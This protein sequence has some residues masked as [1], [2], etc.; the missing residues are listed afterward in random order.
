MERT[1][2]TIEDTCNAGLC[3]G[4]GTC[5]GLCPNS[6]IHMSK[7]RG[8]YVPEIDKKECNRC[9]VCFRVCPGHS[10]DFE[11]LNLM[12]FGKK[13]HKSLIGSYVDCYIGHSTDLKIRYNSSSGG[14]ITG[15]LIFALNEG[16]IDGA[17]VTRMSD[18]RPLDPE[19]FIAKTADEIIGASRSKYCPVPVNIAIKYVLKK[20]GKFAIVGL[21]CH[22]E[23]I[24]KAEIINKELAKKIVL[25]LGLFCNHAPTFLATTYLLEKMNLKKEDV[26]KIDY[27][28]EGWPGRISVTLKNGEKKSVKYFDPYYWGHVFNSYFFTSRCILCNDKV[29]ELSDISFG[30]AWHQSNSKIGESI[31]VSRNKIGEE[32]LRKAAENREIDLKRINNRNVLESQGLY[33]VKRR[34]KARILV[35]KKLGKEVPTYNQKILESKPSDYAAALLSYLRLSISSKPQLWRLLDI[36]PFL[37]THIKGSRND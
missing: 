23:G 21:P 20:N 13:Q 37:M 31:V 26:K 22:I 2:K 8:V 33:L 29:C 12:I 27:R 25:H 3:T 6:A 14:L 24:R 7:I 11:K 30:D 15:L 35:F 17:L 4:C 36:Y 34:H 10:V 9:G 19:V 18:A 16:I 1:N 5:V 28:G 32:L